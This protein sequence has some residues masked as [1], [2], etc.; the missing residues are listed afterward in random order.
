MGFTWHV[1][2]LVRFAVVCRVPNLLPF[3][4]RML[5]TKPTPLRTSITN[6]PLM[7]TKK[8]NSMKRKADDLEASETSLETIAKTYGTVEGACRQRGVELSDSFDED[9]NFMTPLSSEDL[10]TEE[11]KKL[12]LRIKDRLYTD[13]DDGTIRDNELLLLF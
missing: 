11:H 5:K 6:L 7:T 8:T 3:L 2:V 4:E 10:A 1:S 9:D 13:E 12:F